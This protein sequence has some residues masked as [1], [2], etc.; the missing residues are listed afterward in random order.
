MCLKSR[1]E[2]RDCKLQVLVPVP[3]RGSEDERDVISDTEP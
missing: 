1:N 2:E 3:P